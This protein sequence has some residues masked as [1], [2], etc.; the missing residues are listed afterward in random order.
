MRLPADDCVYIHVGLVL[1][2]KA[3]GIGVGDGGGAGRPPPPKKKKS[4]KVF[5][6]QLSC[7]ILVFCYFVNSSYIYFRVNLIKVCLFRADCS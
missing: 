4:G 7:K 6:G 5:F 2:L 3:L 1:L